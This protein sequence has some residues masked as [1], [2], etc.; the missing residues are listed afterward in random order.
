MVTVVYSEFDTGLDDPTQRTEVV[1][2]N[3]VQYE[4]IVRLKIGCAWWE[5]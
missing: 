2:D 5:I 3:V 1:V 4:G